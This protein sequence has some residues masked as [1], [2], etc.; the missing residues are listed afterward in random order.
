M[1]Q[2]Y[3]RMKMH[4]NDDVFMVKTVFGE[5]GEIWCTTYTYVYVSQS[6]DEHKMI[7]ISAM[8]Y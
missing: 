3:F 2:C 8:Q 7:L 6:K 5:I 4:D 1:W